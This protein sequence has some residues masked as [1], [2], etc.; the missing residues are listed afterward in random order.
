MG[1][2]SLSIILTVFVL[3]LHHVGPHQK[4]VP[5]WLQI[6]SYD[7]LSSVLC[8][9]PR[10]NPFM[11][12]T[13]HHHSFHYTDPIEVTTQ[14]FRPNGVLVNRS[15]NMTQ[16]QPAGHSRVTSPSTQ[17]AHVNQFENN[18]NGN[19][20]DPNTEETQDRITSSLKILVEKQDLEERHQ[21]IVN[22]WRFVALIMDRFL[23]W[24]FLFA[25]V[26]SS[27][28]I[29]IVMPMRKPPIE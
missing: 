2:T 20:L 26:I 16:V 27:V 14:P 21:D 22:E 17:H 9:R 15:N 28:V 12:H 18:Y 1:M 7:I 3:Q 5:R 11:Y 10:K 4:G 23:F 24:L 8:M 13:L 29:L 6:L 25:A 19:L